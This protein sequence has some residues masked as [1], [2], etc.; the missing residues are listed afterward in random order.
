MAMLF[1]GGGVG[2]SIRYDL[3]GDAPVDHLEEADPAD[4]AADE[5][6][7]DR[8]QALEARARGRVSANHEEDG[9]TDDEEEDD[10]DE[11]DEDEEMDED[12]DEED[13]D[14]NIS[15]DGYGSA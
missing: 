4:H 12:E 5:S 15:D 2:H 8:L 13:N 6:D 1:L 9:H 10:D 14:V 7:S 3:G 11:L